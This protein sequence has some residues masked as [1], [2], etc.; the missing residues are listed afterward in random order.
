MR[1]LNLTLTLGRSR[2]QPKFWS[3]SQKLFAEWGQRIKS[4]YE[5]ERL[6]DRD[7]SDM[8]LTRSDVFA[9]IEKPFWQP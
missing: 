7:L 4:R 6:D 2:R 9:E 3:N 8:G 1:M 5:L